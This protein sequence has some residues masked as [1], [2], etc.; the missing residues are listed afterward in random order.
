MALSPSWQTDFWSSLI[1]MVHIY[2]HF[3]VAT[4][5]RRRAL[6]G[7]GIL[8]LHG[9]RSWTPQ[10]CLCQQHSEARH[11][12]TSS[13]AEGCWVTDVSLGRELRME[14][15]HP[16]RCQGCIPGNWSRECVHASGRCCC[17]TGHI[18]IGWKCWVCQSGRCNNGTTYFR[19]TRSHLPYF[20]DFSSLWHRF[21]T[22]PCWLVSKS[23]SSMKHRSTYIRVKWPF[24]RR[25]SHPLT[26]TQRDFWRSHTR[27]LLPFR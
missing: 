11:T 15:P 17:L 24:H 12:T 9:A 26:C 7:T 21:Q 16:P 25:V 14:R 8:G 19:T 5:Q 22:F 13:P 27:E 3:R 18:S 23:I 10:S 1:F 2:S 6:S 4:E 20:P